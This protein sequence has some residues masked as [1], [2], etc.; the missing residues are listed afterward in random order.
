MLVAIGLG[1]IGLILIYFE[2]FVPGGILGTMGGLFLAAGL[3]LSIW[4]Q[5]SLIYALFYVVGVIVFLVLTIRLALWKVKRTCHKSHL[6]LADD[7]EGYVAS[8][9]DKELVEKVGEALTSLRPS[10]R[11]KVEGKPYQAVSESGFIK[12]GSKIKIIGGEGA[13]FIVKEEDS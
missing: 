1:I 7:Q 11:I 12:K 4:E 10:G 5:T 9:Y 8:T 13:R 6:Y 2:F 3:F